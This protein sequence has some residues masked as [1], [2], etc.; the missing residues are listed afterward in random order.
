M[1][2]HVKAVEELVIHGADPWIKN[3]SGHL[4]LFEAERAGKDEVAE[5]LATKMGQEPKVRPDIADEMED[6]GLK[7]EDEMKD[8]GTA[9]DAGQTGPS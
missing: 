3:A 8:A 7:G 9:S 5:F 1:N 6:M 4:A 2:G